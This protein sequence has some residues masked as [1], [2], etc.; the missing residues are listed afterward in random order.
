MWDNSKH[1]RREHRRHGDGTNDIAD[2]GRKRRLLWLTSMR[3]KSSNG[4]LPLTFT[5][6]MIVKDGSLE[7]GWRKVRKVN[8]VDAKVPQRRVE[9]PI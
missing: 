8:S 2:P 6:R 4:S 5:T 3:D 9:D 7:V 1:P